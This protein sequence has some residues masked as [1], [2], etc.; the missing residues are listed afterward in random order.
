[1]LIAPILG[2]TSGELLN[3]TLIVKSLLGIT[4]LLPLTLITFPSLSS[5]NSTKSPALIILLSLST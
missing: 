2:L 4:N 3:I 5:E 1:M